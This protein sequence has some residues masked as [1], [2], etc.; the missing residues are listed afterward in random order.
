[1]VFLNW[2]VGWGST[3]AVSRGEKGRS[4]GVGGKSG[5]GD[6]VGMRTSWTTQHL[7]TPTLSIQRGG[8]SVTVV[9]PQANLSCHI[10]FG[11]SVCVF[12]VLF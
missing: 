10:D 8:D 2:E 3:R 1:M 11:W 5:R 4:L 9:A 12:Q 6:S 7:S